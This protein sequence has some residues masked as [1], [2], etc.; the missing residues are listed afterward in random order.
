VGG[1]SHWPAFNLA[2]FAIFVGVV[3]MI[4]DAFLLPGR[5]AS[6]APRCIALFQHHLHHFLLLNIHQIDPSSPI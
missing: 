2:D 6:V 1:T 4:M 3:M 5:G